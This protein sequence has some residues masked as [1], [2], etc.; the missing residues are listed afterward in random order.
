MKIT[1]TGLTKDIISGVALTEEEINDLKNFSGKNAKICYLSDSYF[2][3]EKSES[4]SV[5]RFNS[6][7]NRGHHSIA[8]H[9]FVTVLFE[10]ISKMSAMVLNSLQFYNTSEKSGRYTVMDKG[11][12]RE[13]QLYNKWKDKFEIAIE[14][15]Y[16]DMD[17]NR[18]IKLAQENARYFLSIFNKSTTM[19]Y[20]TSIRQFS[21]IVDW[22]N[23]LENIIDI[24]NQF[25]KNLIDD[26]LEVK[27]AII[28][29]NLY[30]EDL[31]DN[32]DRD[33]SF[34]ARQTT[35]PILQFEKDEYGYTYKT[36]YYGS[37]VQLAQAQRHRTIKY[38][39]DFNGENMDYYIP[40]ILKYDDSLVNEWL[41]DMES[42]KD[43][44]PQATLVKI[45][46]T[47]D[48]PNFILKCKERLCSRA[49]LEICLQTKDT[50]EKFRPY[51]ECLEPYIG[52]YI[53]GKYTPKTKCQLL[54]G[55]K[56]PC[57][58]VNE[59]FTRKI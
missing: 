37:F 40:P 35:D 53:N 33:L 34:L 42:I 28:N 55:C 9:C 43:L 15:E 25:N 51:I 31:K 26:L 3:S 8:D 22:I 59:T 39:M 47:G 44:Y 58:M 52:N 16:P 13:Q 54:N 6:T 27:D 32:K 23:K 38:Y 5:K 56:E 1:I 29:A 17:K 7:T 24:D 49:Q 21:Y 36:S 12:V 4:S 50:L 2:S 14:D 18:I 10:D 11:S 48:I 20:T 45:I 19:S 30:F 41:E 57:H 46:E